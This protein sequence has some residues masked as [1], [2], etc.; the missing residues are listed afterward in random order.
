MRDTF[1]TRE[2]RLVRLFVYPDITPDKRT[3]TRKSSSPLKGMQIRPEI[4]KTSKQEGS[5]H[6]SR[7]ATMSSSTSEAIDYIKKPCEEVRAAAA[8]NMSLVAD[9]L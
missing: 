7:S 5:L 1:E 2:R 8:C 3:S 6:V 9:C 4:S